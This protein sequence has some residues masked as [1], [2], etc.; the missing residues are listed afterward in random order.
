MVRLDNIKLNTRPKRL[1]KAK[2]QL[3]RAKPVQVIEQ[4]DPNSLAQSIKKHMK[5]LGNNVDDE[6]YEVS[7]VIPDIKLSSLSNPAR[8]IKGPKLTIDFNIRKKNYK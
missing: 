2:P 5:L 7:R 4:P 6:D 8:F 3:E 1:S